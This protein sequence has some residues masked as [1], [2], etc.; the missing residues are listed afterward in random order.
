MERYR[1]SITNALRFCCWMVFV[2]S[3]AAERT[4]AVLRCGPLRP[5]PFGRTAPGLALQPRFSGCPEGGALKPT[6]GAP[7]PAR[8]F[9]KATPHNS[10]S[11][12][13]PAD[14]WQVKQK[15]SEYFVYSRAF[16]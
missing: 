14:F 12:I 11:R 5:R 13:A 8:Y 9:F 15:R 6:G 10:K 4:G 2:C 16:L 3:R 1:A 7:F